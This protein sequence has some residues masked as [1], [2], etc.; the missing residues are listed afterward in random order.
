M[1]CRMS[2]VVALGV[3][4]LQKIE[5]PP[6]ISATYTDK[7]GEY[8]FE[9]FVVLNTKDIQESQGEQNISVAFVGFS[10]KIEDP[11]VQKQLNYI[12]PER[13]WKKIISKY[14]QMWILL[15]VFLLFPIKNFKIRNGNIPIFLPIPLFI[16]T[17]GGAYE[18]VK[19]PSKEDYPNKATII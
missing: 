11:I 2:D 12:E 9:P 1:V 15:L 14:P 18:K 3:E 16:S 5:G 7:N 6:M 4:T 8:L 13:A 10:E 19:Y 17:R